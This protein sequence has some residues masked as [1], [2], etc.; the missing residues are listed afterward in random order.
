MT[1]ATLELPTAPKL[2]RTGTR[3][4]GSVAT[5]GIRFDYDGAIPT[6]ILPGELDGASAAAV[7][8]LADEF[9]AQGAVKL[10]LDLR[11]LFSAD[12]AGLAALRDAAALLSEC[13]GVLA[14]AAPRPRMRY[15]MSR[16]GTADQ[17]VV[18]KTVDEA[19][20]ALSG[21]CPSARGESAAELRRPIDPAARPVVPALVSALSRH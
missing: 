4:A 19:V 1:A 5:L 7:E 15:T 17:F 14:L 8:K 9:A 3:P 13:D 11:R 10:V 21:V 20:R 18:Y 12:L 2:S 16:M 6:A